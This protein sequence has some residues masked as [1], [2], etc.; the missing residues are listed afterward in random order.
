MAQ[1]PEMKARARLLAQVLGA[2]AAAEAAGK[3]EGDWRLHHVALP[4]GPGDFTP[5]P[6]PE[7]AEEQLSPL[8]QLLECLAEVLGPDHARAIAQRGLEAGQ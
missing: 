5:Y 2:A 8:G 4:V 7:Y 6:V 3:H 1:T